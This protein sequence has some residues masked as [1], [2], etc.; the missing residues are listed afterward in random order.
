MVGDLVT[1]VSVMNLR[2]DP[3]AAFT[4]SVSRAGVLDSVG[5]TDFAS[6]PSTSSRSNTCSSLQIRAKSLL[7]FPKNLRSKAK[8]TYMS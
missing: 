1:S 3:K 6:L 4:A 5:K 7:N 8:L 2:L